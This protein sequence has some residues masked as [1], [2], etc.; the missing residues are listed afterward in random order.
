MIWHFQCAR[1]SAQLSLANYYETESG[2]YCCDVCPDVEAAATK[3]AS[4]A[5]SAINKSIEDGATSEEEE[6]E[7]DTS[8]DESDHEQGLL[9]AINLHWFVFCQGAFVNVV[10]YPG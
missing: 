3:A 6:D 5:A 1:C 2:D 4:S 10:T 8:E 9:S 7:E